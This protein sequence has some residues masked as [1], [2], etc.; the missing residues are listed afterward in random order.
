M[1]SFGPVSS[2]PVSSLPAE[3][4]PAISPAGSVAAAGALTLATA[5]SLAGSSTG[6]GSL[7][8]AAAKLLAGSE[9]ASGALSNLRTIALSVGGS[10]TAAGSLRKAVAKPLA[11]SEAASG[12][13]ARVDAKGLT[14]SATPA[15]ALRK[16]I[17]KPLA[18]SETGA[19]ALRKAVAKLLA[20]SE[21]S[22][23]ALSIL[24]AILTGGSTTAA[25]SLR[26]DVA[27]PLAGSST[28][29][30]SLQKAISKTISRLIYSDNFTGAD[31]TN[32]TSRGWT[33]DGTYT[34]AVLIESNQAL[35]PPSN[36]PGV[37][38]VDLG[39][40]DYELSMDLICN[41]ALDTS[42]VE[43]GF[44]VRYASTGNFWVC[45]VSGS[46]GTGAVVQIYEVV[47]GVSTLRGNNSFV[48]SGYPHNYS[49]SASVSGTTLR[50][51]IDGVV[52]VTAFGMTT[53]L[54]ATK[55]GMWLHDH[56][57]EGA[58]NVDNFQAT[59]GAYGSPTV[60][61]TGGITKAVAKPLAGSSAP[62][63]S[64]VKANAK[65]L[66]G[67]ETGAGAIAKAVAKGLAGSVTGSGD[68]TNQG[69]GVTALNVAGSLSASGE[70]AKSVAKS[71]A[72]SVTASG[73]ES[74]AASGADTLL[75]SG[76]LAGA[77]AL[78]KQAAKGVGGSSTPAGSL[79]K[80]AAKTDSGS[81][82]PAGSLAKAETKAIVG[83]ITPTGSLAKAVAKAAGGAVTASGAMVRV[84]G[85]VLAGS[86]AAAS[87][88]A[89]AVF[90]ALA[91][92]A[93]AAGGLGINTS[94]PGTS[95]PSGTFHR[96]PARRAF[97]INAPRVF[98]RSAGRVF[99]GQLMG[100]ILQ[101]KLPADTNEARTYIFDFSQCDEAKAGETLLSAT[102]PAV[103]GVT[104]GSPT[105][106]TADTNFVPAGLGV[107][108][109]LVVAA[110][111][112]YDLECRG[113]FS[114][115]GTVVVKGQL[116]GE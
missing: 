73:D 83:S 5:K 79:A 3:A 36:P 69:S 50:F 95:A 27:K 89:K 52:V 1:P 96:S 62:V 92:S 21:S 111:L 19:G 104:I 4:G 45:Y 11:G 48:L 35:L 70:V 68:E 100:T 115:G 108:V 8:K 75:L 16:A 103:S 38:T 72:G 66:A 56:L 82:A 88:L 105:V 24:R 91:G 54:S 32:L 113:L 41:S 12:S 44:V 71:I 40:T 49:L 101:T 14:G 28:H 114:G 53:G 97:T 13:L 65:V 37:V 42:P 55:A 112:T 86:I 78:T 39:V 99:K 15:G 22:S 110:A 76:S 90:K 85:K 31:G 23:G 20:G 81:M 102:V 107:K 87:S 26:K 51:L 61:A 46:P 57:P 60:S 34:N 17:A 67:S 98:K 7:A 47:A 25:G 64:L 80:A 10:T 59:S 77:G 106:L 94:L 9:T 43:A 74:N 18:G 6:A 109:S 58:F 93:T 29:A 2:L 116:I 30:G 63:G 33:Q 84:A